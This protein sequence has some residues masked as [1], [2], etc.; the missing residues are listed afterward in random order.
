M[1]DALM[2]ESEVA[3]RLQVSVA[4]VR[5]WRLERRGPKFIKLGAL[6]RYRSDDIERWLASCPAGGEAPV[7]NSDAHTV[8]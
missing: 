4:C 1:L 2:N 5:R 3:Q 6:V 7:I 8:V